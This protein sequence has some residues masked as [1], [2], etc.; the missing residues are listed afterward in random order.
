[1]SRRVLGAPRGSSAQIEKTGLFL[2]KS[3]N[4]VTWRFDWQFPL[5]LA[6][7]RDMADRFRALQALHSQHETRRTAPRFPSVLV[8]AGFWKLPRKSPVRRS[9]G[10]PSCRLDEK[11]EHRARP[12][13]FFIDADVPESHGTSCGCCMQ[14][15]ACAVCRS[16]RLSLNRLRRTADAACRRPSARS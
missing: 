15:A 10:R 3:K 16:V 8:S 12:R 4:Q 7:R 6:S 9:E 1:M 13:A 5:M 2:S 11:R 14:E